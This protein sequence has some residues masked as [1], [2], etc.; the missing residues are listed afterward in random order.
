[1]S[2][3][4]PNEGAGPRE[5]RGARQFSMMPQH[6]YFVVPRLRERDD[7][8]VAARRKFARWVGEAVAIYSRAPLDLHPQ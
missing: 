7:Y 6:A 2:L 3:V 8:E 5:R 4:A 1:M